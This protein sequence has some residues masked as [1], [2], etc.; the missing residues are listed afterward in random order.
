MDLPRELIQRE[1]IFIIMLQISALQ[2][3]SD[4]KRATINVGNKKYGRQDS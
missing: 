4:K 2:N 3:V 1:N